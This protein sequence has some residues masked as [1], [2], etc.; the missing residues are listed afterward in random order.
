MSDNST[1]GHAGF[2]LALLLGEEVGV[3]VVEDVDV[4]GS[5]ARGLSTF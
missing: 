2:F 1:R 3:Y 5:S 4:V